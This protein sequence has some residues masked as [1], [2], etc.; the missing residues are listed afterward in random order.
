VMVELE[1]F[2]FTGDVEAFSKAAREVA[3]W[4]AVFSDVTFP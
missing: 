2:A 4:A 3:N 1:T